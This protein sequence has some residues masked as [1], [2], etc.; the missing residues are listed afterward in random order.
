M[1]GAALGVSPAAMI[2]GIVEEPRAA[3]PGGGRTAEGGVGVRREFPTFRGDPCN[4]LARDSDGLR[5]DAVVVGA[6]EQAGRRIIGSVAVRLVEAGRW[7][8][9]VVP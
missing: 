6:S 4:G 8:V 3:D 5:A 9:T 2:H 1:A 7:P